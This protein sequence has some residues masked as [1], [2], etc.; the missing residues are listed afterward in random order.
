[1]RSVVMLFCVV[2]GVGCASIAAS[3]T[4]PFSVI[5]N[6][7]GAEVRLNGNVVGTTPTLISV[8]RQMEAPVV[9]VRK[10]GHSTESCRLNHA[11]GGGYVAADVI[12]CVFLFPIGCVSFIDANGSWNVLAEAECRVSLMPRTAQD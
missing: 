8:P 6:P 10:A 1:M 5:S 11:A 9:E 4:E 7:P 3:R 2:F 12:M